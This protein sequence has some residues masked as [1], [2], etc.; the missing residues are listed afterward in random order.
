MSISLYGNLF[1]VIVELGMAI[2]TGSQAVLLDAVYD[3]IEFFM[4]LPSIFLI[5]LLYKPASEDHPYG[6]MQLET[7]FLVLKGATM[8]AVTIGLIANNVLFLIHGGRSISFDTVAYFELFACLLGVF[9]YLFLHRKNKNLNSP[10]ITAE[11]TGWKIDSVISLGMT[12]AFFL[13]KWIPWAWFRPF[14][15]YL[16]PLITVIL[17]M[18][19]LPMPIR[20]VITAFRDLMLIPP[21]EDTIQEIKST[22][23]PFLDICHGVSTYYSIV[24]TGR[25]LWIRAYV[26]FEKEEISLRRLHQIQNQ[27]VQALKEKYAD[28]WFELLPDFRQP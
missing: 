17:S 28:F 9:V 23:D 12:L 25:K 5:P 26:V 27:C 18:I 1:F 8:T 15:P 21:E 13:P 19:M 7:I 24:R 22:V 6:Y 16:D 2:Y 20:T 14:V 3:G 10:L 4:L 11:A